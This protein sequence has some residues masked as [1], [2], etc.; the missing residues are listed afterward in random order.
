LQSFDDGHLAEKITNNSNR[1]TYDYSSLRLLRSLAASSIWLRQPA[2]CSFCI[3]H[4]AFCISFN[5]PL[6]KIRNYGSILRHER[7]RHSQ[8]PLRQPAAGSV[9]VERGLAEFA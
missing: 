5:S 8:F 4:S 1:R 7:R 9:S 2:L 3:F 6:T